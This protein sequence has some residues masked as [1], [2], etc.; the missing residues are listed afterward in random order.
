MAKCGWIGGVIVLFF[1]AALSDYM[2]C[3]LYKAV[4]NHPKGDPI[5]TYEELGRVCFGRA[6]QIITALI[7]HITMIG[8]CAT[9]LLL[10]GQN[11]QKLAPEL[12]VTV[13]CV[14]WAAI[15]V[16]LSWIR[17]LKDMS[18]VA[19]VGLMGIIALFVIIAANG[20]VHGV[21]TDEE[22]EYDLISQ[23]PL[24][25]AISFGNAVLSYQIASAT[26]N[27][28][29]EM[30]TPSAFPKVASISFFIVFSIYVG[31]G[32]CGYYGYGRSLVEVPILDSITPPDQPLDAWGYALVVS[33]LALAFPHY[34][35]LLMPIA[36]SLEEAVK[37][38]IKS[39][40]KRDFIK[41]AVARTIL[42]AITLVI[43]ITVPSVNNL[44]NLMS[45][46]TVIAMAAILPALFYVRM[47]VLN[48][49]SFA[50]VVKSN[51]I[52]MSIIL[53]LTLL[54]LLLMGAGGYVAIVTF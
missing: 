20:I 8:V 35:V 2:V 5:N 18:Y 54:C 48:E 9:L 53:F 22:I 41:R 6:G 26:P 24:N 4:T 3:N 13:W 50:A 44:I 47:K 23:D 17:S 46:F 45:V 28:L 16:P 51:W 30:K 10:L 38:E 31:V 42:V 25:W 39:S 32:A 33:M 27:L 37:I 11:T 19:I 34:L 15:C 40:S 49:G 1:G 14:I 36:A 12:S 43:A 52:E 21:T 29:R 7:V